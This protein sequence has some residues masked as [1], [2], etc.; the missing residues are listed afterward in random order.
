VNAEQPEGE[1]A[2]RVGTLEL[3]VKMWPGLSGYHKPL[4]EHDA[5]FSDVMKVLDAAEEIGSGDGDSTSTRDSLHD[6]DTS[7]DSE[8]EG[9]GDKHENGERKGSLVSEVK[10]Y[11]TRKDEL[12]RKHRGM[13]QW[14]AVRKLAWVGHNVE[15]AAEGVE[16]RVKSKF[17]H[18]QAEQGMDVEA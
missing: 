16:Q 9:A 6:A 3:T 12:H 17:K 5:N 7:S 18:N 11:K 13:M 15:E 2:E 14:S 8:N 1:R 4:A 10:D